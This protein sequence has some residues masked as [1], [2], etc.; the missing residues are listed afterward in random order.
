MDK[1]VEIPKRSERPPTPKERA[2]AEARARKHAQDIY[3]DICE[4]FEKNFKRSKS[5]AYANYVSGMM[6][7]ARTLVPLYMS[8]TEHMKL[9]SEA[10]SNIKGNEATAQEDPREMMA[11]WLRGER[12]LTRVPFEARTEKLQ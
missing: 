3:G 7:N 12:D 2:I 8:A 6:K 5:M 10:A 1:P 9:V 11:E 4:E